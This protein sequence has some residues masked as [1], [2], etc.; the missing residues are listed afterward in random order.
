MSVAPPPSDATLYCTANDDIVDFFDKYDAFLDSD[1]VLV[2]G[3][4]KKKSNVSSADMPDDNNKI[5]PTNPT[6]TEVE[7]RIRAA[8]NW[9][10]EFTGHAWRERTV[11]NEYKSLRTMMGGASNYYWRAGTPIKLMKRSVRTPLDS[12]KGDKIEF[13]EGGSWTDWVSDSGYT[14]GREN[15]YWVDE[16]TGTL[17]VYRRHIF[18]QRHKEVRVTYRYGKDTIPQ[19]IRDVCARRTAAHYLE[20]QQF[21]VTTPGNEQAPDSASLAEKWRETCK[22]DLRPYEEVR[23]IGTM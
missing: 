4:V 13:W 1:E 15:D 7:R 8:S 16:S 23:T 2:D 3:T 18:F 19:A 14:E 12:S 22:E 17:Y 11:E 20:T 9:I 10:D 5:G 6:K 21:R